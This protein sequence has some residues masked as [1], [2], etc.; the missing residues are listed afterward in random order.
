MITRKEFPV[1]S[2]VVKYFPKALLEVS[3]ISKVG[4]DQHNPDQELHWSKEK[5]KDHEDALMR[6]LLDHS[7]DPVDTDNQLHLAKVAWR[8]LAALEVYIETRKEHKHT[9]W[10]EL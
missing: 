1:Y 10:P 5:S 4:N 3:R 6:H 2:G 9:N 8:A 7:I